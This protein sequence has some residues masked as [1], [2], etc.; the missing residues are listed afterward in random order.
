MTI[1]EIVRQIVADKGTRMIRPRKEVHI[2]GTPW[3]YDMK[4]LFTGNKG[5][6]VFVDLFTASAMTA[7]Y[8]ALSDEN[9]GKFDLIP[10]A[11][12]I[13]FTWRNVK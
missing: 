11:Q 13:D 9:K 1:S 8:N 10:L 5:G 12:L 6:W 3:Q 4:D 7:I 2:R